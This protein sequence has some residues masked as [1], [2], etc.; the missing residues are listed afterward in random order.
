MTCRAIVIVV[1]S[2]ACL[3][4]GCAG[5]GGNASRPTP[6]AH[7]NP[8]RLPPIYPGT[9]VSIPPSTESTQASQPAKPSPTSH[10]FPGDGTFKV[11]TDIQPGTYRSQGAH[12]CYWERLR[13]LSGALADTIANGAGNWPQ[14]VEILPTDVAFKTQQCPSWTP[15]SGAPTTTSSTSKTPVA[16]PP[17]A[18]VC[19]SNGGSAG[20]FTTSAVGSPDTSCPFAEQVRLAYAASGEPGAG[21]RQVDATSPVTGQ[22]YTMTCSPNGSLMVCKGGNGAVVYL[23]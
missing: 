6:T 15:D 23:Y 11:G 10:G 14:V 22:H 19:P 1:A 2:A 4:T 12:S 21:P 20:A 5:S 7:E 17:G 13:G 9:T 8:S 18:Q 3:V 16:L